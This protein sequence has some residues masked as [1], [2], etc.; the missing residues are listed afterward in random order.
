MTGIQQM[1]QNSNVLV[2]SSNKMVTEMQD[3]ADE[4]RLVVAKDVLKS[5]SRQHETIKLY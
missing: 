1:A 5:L 3:I 4:P 2:N